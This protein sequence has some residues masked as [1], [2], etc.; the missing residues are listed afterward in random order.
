VQAQQPGGTALP[1]PAGAELRATLDGRTA[2]VKVEDVLK[3]VEFRVGRK[4]QE[5]FVAYR[6]D[7]PMPYDEPFVVQARFSSEPPF[8]QTT[9]T[10][11]WENGG[12]QEVP[13]YK[14]NSDPKLFE[15]E[16]HPFEDPSS[17]RGLTFC[18]EGAEENSWTVEP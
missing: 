6:S 9:V 2:I 11:K 7:E 14:S 8:H 15:S 18:I 10:L 17:C 16:E 3:I 13:V 12:R 5:R 1:V 4:E